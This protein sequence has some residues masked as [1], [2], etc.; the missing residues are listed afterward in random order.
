MKGLGLLEARRKIGKRVSILS[1]KRRGFIFAIADIRIANSLQR[2]QTMTAP[3]LESASPPARSVAVTA[4]KPFWPPLLAGVALGLV[5]LLTFFVTGHGL[6]ASGFFM[7][8]A[9]AIGVEVAPQAMAANPYL[10]PVAAD[11]P[12]ASWISWEILGLFLGAL[13]ASLWSGRFRLMVERGHTLPP[14]QR[15][16]L[17]LGGGILTGFGARLAQGC[18]SGLGLSGGATLGVAAFLFLIGFFAAGFAT[19][20]L[21]RRIWQ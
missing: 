8:V 16:A 2:R 10:G 13:T 3:S 20:A 15:L 5:L 12:L 1:K 11:R 9:A 14:A 19:R 17:A 18:T 6:G 21:A 4:P 7:R